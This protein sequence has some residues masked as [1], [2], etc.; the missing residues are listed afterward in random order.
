MSVSCP[1]VI[2][3]RHKR[4]H[5]GALI[6]EGNKRLRVQLSTGKVLRINKLQ[7]YHTFEQSFPQDS[8]SAK[9]EAW[10][11]ELKVEEHEVDFDALWRAL[12]DEQEYSLAQA[13]ER[14]FGAC[15]DAGLLALSEAFGQR[16]LDFKLRNSHLTRVDPETRA[17]IHARL[18]EEARINDENAVFVPWF[19]AGQDPEKAAPFC[20]ELLE[21][22][23]N[24]ALQGFDKSPKRI[25]QLAR[26]MDCRGSDELLEL[27]IDQGVFGRDINEVPHRFALRQQASPEALD[28]AQ[29]RLH[30]IETVDAGVR[31]STELWGQREDLREVYTVTIDQQVT[32]DIDDAVSIWPHGEGF[33]VGVHIADVSA[34]VVKGTELDESAAWRAS[35]VYFFD[36]VV[37]MLPTELV[38]KGLSLRAGLERPALSLILDLDKDGQLIGEGRFTRSLIRVDE[39]LT[40]KDT[41]RPPYA[42]DERFQRLKSL[43]LSLRARREKEGAVVLLRGETSVSF[44]DGEVQY[45]RVPPTTL[46]HTVVSELAVAYSHAAG[47]FISGHEQSALFKVQADEVP[48]P[49][50][51]LPE[52][53]RWL[54]VHFPPAKLSVRPGP[55]RTLG[56]DV[57]VQST[58]PIRRYSDLVAQR[59]IVALLAEQEVPYSRTQLRSVKHGQ[60]R[61]LV[62]IRRMEDQR[63][64]YWLHR[65]MEYDPGPHEA[66][67]SRLESGKRPWVYLPDWHY[68]FPLHGLEPEE[69]EDFELGQELRVVATEFHARQ[70]WTRMELF[71][72]E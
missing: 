70:R 22:L 40:Y 60:E 59:Q 8:F 10:L 3:E 69:S 29:R 42:S 66:I 51:S 5:L 28:E 16:V 19:E 23:K 57:Y 44:E 4:L 12:E 61:A 34:T 49:D 31:S 63:V 52:N 47:R 6:G 33:R 45:R 46:G 37:S 21:G 53:L 54:R 55:H 43:A 67:V 71:G 15:F 64:R 26:V 68:E 18:A 27:F 11:K 24:M 13:C 30:D 2:I 25:R 7:L 9:L 72:L 65:A 1:V 50:M 35:S 41:E 56:L 39:R 32:H 38:E 14:L 17:K 58:A 20:L 62:R 36:S 48:Q